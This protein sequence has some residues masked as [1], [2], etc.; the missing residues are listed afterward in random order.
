MFDFK[1]SNPLAEAAKKI[2]D[3][4]AK[5]RS[6]VAMVNEALGIQ[7]RNQLTIQDKPSYDTLLELAQAP[8]GQILVET[9]TRKDFQMVAELIRTHADPEKRK[10]LAL[11][12]MEVFTR[13]NTR[14]D[15]VRFLKAAGVD[16]TDT[17]H[18]K[19]LKEDQEDQTARNTQVSKTVQAAPFVKDDTKAPDDDD[20][21]TDTSARSSS[22]Q[23][24][25]KQADLAEGKDIGKEGKNFSKIAKSAGKE[26]GSK[27]A[28]KRVAGA[29]LNKLRHE[30]PGKYPT[31]VK[32]E[33]K[34]ALAAVHGYL[35]EKNYKQDNSDIIK[36]N[37]KQAP[38]Y[39]Q[40]LEEIKGKLGAEVLDEGFNSEFD[41]A[42]RSGQSTFTYKGKSYNTMLKG[43]TQA[44][45]KSNLAKAAPPTPASPTAAMTA[46]R[47][48]GQP[49]ASMSAS[50]TA[51]SSTGGSGSGELQA[52]PTPHPQAA[53]PAPAPVQASKQTVDFDVNKE[54]SNASA[55][56]SKPAIVNFDVN[57]EVSSASSPPLSQDMVQ[58]ALKEDVLPMLARMS[59]AQK[60]KDKPRYRTMTAV[61]S[62][63]R[64]NENN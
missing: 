11:H 59:M 30:H 5:Q 2:M 36:E 42:R 40:V 49:G 23:K 21:A 41:L 34:W 17:G 3:Q 1:K 25:L 53:A 4:N 20:A 50:G 51:Q 7:S 14:F 9:P 60:P 10:E 15:P 64:Q 44:Q 52:R 57:K 22:I 56:P 61:Y 26:Y 24:D 19:N 18:K 37:T 33:N 31:H 47:E 16:E 54:V 35:E 32:E 27:E 45:W 28:G 39:E 13:Q 55:P 46:S 63:V 12:H 38:T 6:I 48:G 62:E 43:E 8:S 29:I 58:K